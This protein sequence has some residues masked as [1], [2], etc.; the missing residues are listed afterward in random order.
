MKTFSYFLD[1]LLYQPRHNRTQNSP[2]ELCNRAVT[3][4]L[5]KIGYKG[6]N[7]LLTGSDNDRKEQTSDTTGTATINIG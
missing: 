3:L 1:T 5:S 7:S 2:P 6:L 4:S